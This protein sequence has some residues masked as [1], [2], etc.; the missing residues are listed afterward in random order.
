MVVGGPNER[1]DFHLNDGEEI[2]FQVEG[3]ILVRLIVDGEVEEVEVKEGDIFLLPAGVPHQ[4][5]RP[6]GTVGLVI[7]RYRQKEEQDG[8]L[9]YCDNC[10]EKLHEVFIPIDNIVE[11]LPA[12][13]RAFAEDVDMRT[14][15]H[16]GHIKHLADPNASQV[17]R[18][19]KG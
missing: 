19:K 1:M 17:V 15:K 10:G 18:V 6:E 13:T 7:E 2:F 8:F 12:V 11:Q 14:C 16:C 9:W 4:P 5:I 3:D